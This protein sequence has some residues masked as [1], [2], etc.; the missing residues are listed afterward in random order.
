[1]LRLLADSVE[2]SAPSSNGWVVIAA[3]VRA[4]NMENVPISE[5]SVNWLLRSIS[6]DGM[7]AFGPKTIWHGLQNAVRSFLVFEHDSNN[8]HKLLDLESESAKAPGT[9][10][11]TSIAHW[12]ALRAT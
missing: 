7:V 5:N 1:M 6:T 10:Q 9:S 4:Y 3:L 2:F 12:L 8:F 11:A